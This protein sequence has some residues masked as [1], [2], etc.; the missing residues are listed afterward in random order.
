MFKIR[1]SYWNEYKNN[2]VDISA[3]AHW[4][5]VELKKKTVSY[6]LFMIFEPIGGSS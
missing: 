6:D 5:N 4:K 3:Y 2:L 1:P